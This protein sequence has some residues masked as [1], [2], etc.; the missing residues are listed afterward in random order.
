MSRAF[1][2][3][4]TA[5]KMNGRRKENRGKDRNKVNEVVIILLKKA[6]RISLLN[7]GYHL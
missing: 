1:N 6:L 7:F 3:Q 2:L 4:H 5:A